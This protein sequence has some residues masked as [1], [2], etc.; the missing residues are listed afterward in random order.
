MRVPFAEAVDWHGI[1]QTVV[2]SIVAGVGLSAAYG[3][4]LLGYVR[5]REHYAEGHQHQAVAYGLVGLAGL[6]V[7]L[8]GVTL[9]I[10]FIAKD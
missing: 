10:I 4:T 6:A 8:T 7:T 2:V 3:F 1:G 5:A 9:G